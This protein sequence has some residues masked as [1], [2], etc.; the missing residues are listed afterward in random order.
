MF[1]EKL[2]KILIQSEK[3]DEFSG[4]FY[5]ESAA[6]LFKL[7]ACR[8]ENRLRQNRV[9]VRQQGRLLYVRPMSVVG[10]VSLFY[11]IPEIAYAVASYFTAKEFG[12]AIP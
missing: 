4:I 11:C 10:T 6:I 8:S 1:K 7:T 5:A 3:I 2:V 12:F 9:Y